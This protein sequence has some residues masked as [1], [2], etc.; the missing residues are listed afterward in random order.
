MKKLV[1]FSILLVCGV[2]LASSVSAQAVSGTSVIA[3]KEIVN[4]KLASGKTYMTQGN[5]QLLTTADPKHPLNGASGD[6]D[7]ACIVDA[8][9]AAMCMGS[10]EFVDREGDLAFFTWDGGQESGSWRLASGSGKW[11]GASGQGTWKN[12]GAA[13]AGNF[14]RNT[15]EG[16]MSMATMKK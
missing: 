15:W 9:N 2:L 13:V 3:P 11:K 16:S 1:V 6:C 5:H 4:I 8:S 7:G 10:C 14:A 12:A